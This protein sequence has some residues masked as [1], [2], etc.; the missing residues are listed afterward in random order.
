MPEKTLIIISIVLFSLFT[1]SVAIAITA[2]IL[3]P[4]SKLLSVGGFVFIIS[5]ITLWI[6][7]RKGVREI[8]ELE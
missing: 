5:L 1:S 4:V 3:Y 7:N 6:L 2:L 8:D